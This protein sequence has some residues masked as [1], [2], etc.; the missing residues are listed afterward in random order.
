MSQRFN[1]V[2]GQIPHLI[3]C[4]LSQEKKIQDWSS[5]R[6]SK[7]LWKSI[8]CSAEGRSL[9]RVLS[10][11]LWTKISL[12]LNYWRRIKSFPLKKG[13]E[14]KTK[15]LCLWTSF[16]SHVMRWRIT[17]PASRFQNERQVSIITSQLLSVGVGQ[18]S[19]SCIF[20]QHRLQRRQ[21]LFSS[22]FFM[23]KTLIMCFTPNVWCILWM[24]AFKKKRSGMVHWCDISF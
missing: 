19:R 12:H 16:Q 22:Q 7:S 24:L 4:V 13:T 5:V 9:A 3:S 17:I 20:Q 15:K 10:W 14:N 23:K 6:Y 11:T 2:K 21:D 18:T 8:Q 1:F